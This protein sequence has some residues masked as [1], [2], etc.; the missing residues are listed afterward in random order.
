VRARVAAAPLVAVVLAG[1]VGAADV[2][3]GLDVGAQYNSNLFGTPDGEGDFSGRIGPRLRAMDEV[4]KLTWDLRYWPT[5]EK[6]LDIGEA[7]GWDH[8][9]DLKAA[10]RPSEVT[11]LR[12]TER[13]LDTGNV[14]EVLSQDGTVDSGFE[15]GRERRRTNNATLMLEHNLAPRH[16][17]TLSLQ[18]SDNRF[19]DS[20][21][22][23]SEVTAAR[24][25]H[26]YT[27]DRL[28]RLGLG[29]SFTEQEVSGVVQPVAVF[30][31]QRSSD[32]TRYYHLSLR[33]IHQVDPTLSLDASAGPTWIRQPRSDLPSSVELV[34][35]PVVGSPAGQLLLRASSCPRNGLGEFLLAPGRCQ[36]Y[37]APGFTFDP[38]G[39]NQASAP[40]LGG[41]PGSDESLTYFADITLTKSWRDFNLSLGYNRDAS[42]TSELSGVVLD[43][44][45]ASLRWM[46]SRRWSLNLQASYQRR[47]QPSSSLVPQVIVEPATL[48]GRRTVVVGVAPDGTPLLGS[49]P[50]E[51]SDVAE[52]AGFRYVT[53][54]SVL[55]IDD[56]FGSVFASYQLNRRT[57]LYL[58]VSYQH[59]DVRSEVDRVL[60]EQSNWDRFYVAIGVTYTLPPFHLPF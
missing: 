41:D 20:L 52:V 17:T 19:E 29:L 53:R 11:A 31:S 2:E 39:G 47:E 22:D 43:T 21:T 12:F 45:S 30:S 5:Y 34:R 26:L 24:A 42:T 54:E 38:I 50:D 56:Y 36:P 25:S 8:D 9:L 37:I 58:Q 51:A 13:F 33:W 32:P 35:Y 15:F 55:E 46:P 7:D 23:K 18:R 6:F 59:E 10:W 27:L 40:R 14:N 1:P 4:G 16:A 60:A 48:P 57:R 3:L 28:N 49:V 44:V